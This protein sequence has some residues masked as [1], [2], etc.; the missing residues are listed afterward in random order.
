MK[1]LLLILL[2]FCCFLSFCLASHHQAEHKLKVGI[3]Y[4]PP[5]I[6]TE[7]GKISGISVDLWTLISDTLKLAY[8]YKLYNSRDSLMRD[9]SKGII[10]LTIL[11]L[12]ATSERLAKFRL[13]IPFF[14]SNMGIATRIEK[15]SPYLQLLKNIF[16][17][18]IIRSMLFILLIATIFAFFLWLAERKANPKEFRPGIKGVSDGIWWAF[19]TM[20]TVGYGDKI[21]K[22]R[23]GRIL[24]IL[25]M[26]FAIGMFFIASGVVSSELT[27]RKLQSQIK[28]SDDLS[29]CKVGAVDKTGYAE[30]LKRHNILYLPFLSPWD[31]LT[32]VYSGFTDAFVYDQAT[33]QYLVDRY[34]LKNKIVI[35]PSGLNLQ[36]FS[37]MTSKNNPEVIERINPALLNVIDSDV[38]GTILSKYGIDRKH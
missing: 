18:K 25:W 14:I 27:V 6:L 13:S 31:G 29:S 26:F 35:I 8:E 33:L 22:T 9:L 4:S 2:F 16:S 5:Y 20:T 17:W 15:Q 24:A 36:Y 32:S 37:F 21:P 11:P 7:K 3:A 23:I 19:V 10:D 30:T 1:R 34:K 38:W 12:T 28:N